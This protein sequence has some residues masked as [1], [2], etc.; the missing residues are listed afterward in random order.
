MA[1]SLVVGGIVGA[2]RGVGWRVV[3]PSL[4]ST[5]TTTSTSEW[6]STLHRMLYRVHVV[7]SLLIVQRCP[8]RRG[9]IPYGR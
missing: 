5:R 8:L 2:D 1:V 9:A 4:G 6:I 3:V 7:V